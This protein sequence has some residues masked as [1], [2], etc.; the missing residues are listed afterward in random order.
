MKNN[1]N[2]LF[3]LETPN[4]NRGGI[5]MSTVILSNNLRKR[6]YRIN[7]AYFS[8]MHDYQAGDEAFTFK[9]Y[10][11]E[12]EMKRIFY[13]E[14]K[15]RKIDIII[16][17]DINGSNMCALFKMIRKDLHIPII[18]CV[19]TLPDHDRYWKLGWYYNLTE[20]LYKLRKGHFSSAER[21]I[22]MYSSVDRYVLLSPSFINIAKDYYNLSDCSKFRVIPNAIEPI[23]NN[24]IIKFDDKPKQFLIVSRLVE[25]PKNITAALRIW[26]KFE[27]KNQDYTL[28]L[29][30]YGPDENKILNYASNLNLRNFEFIGKTNNPGILYNQSRYFMMTS[31]CEGFGMTLVEA[32]QY[33]CIPFAFD[34]YASLHDIV[35]DSY[36]GFIINNGNENMYANKMLECVKDVNISRVS[37]NAVKSVAKFDSSLITDR[38]ELLF[39]ELCNI[40][41]E[42]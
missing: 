25:H 29:A 36:N 1:L 21:Y 2:I 16:D 38:W 12:D 23:D 34:S 5:A 32:Q 24:N 4:P 19:H 18:Y 39:N 22:E 10:S 8:H 33:G 35:D 7:Y 15:K 31:I 17:Q 3:I 13:H 6:G 14:L 11:S 40:K 37:M 9:E 41:L 28:K 20:Y 26:K 27:D 42:S 30:G